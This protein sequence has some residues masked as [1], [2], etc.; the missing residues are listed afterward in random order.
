MTIQILHAFFLLHFL[1]LAFYKV[2]AFPTLD[3]AIQEPKYQ[4]SKLFFRQCQLQ[5]TH[6]LLFHCV[7]L[8]V[9]SSLL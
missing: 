2:L 6:F 7:G 4:V 8:L 5:G 3:A 9:C 1:R